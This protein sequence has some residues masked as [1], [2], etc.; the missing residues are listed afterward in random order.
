MRNALEIER[1]DEV[2][3]AT[4]GEEI[5]ISR[6]E[7][8]SYNGECCARAHRSCLLDY[9]PREE[10]P[11]PTKPPYIAFVGNLAFDIYEDGI[12]EF[13][14]PSTLKDIKIIKDRDEKP[15]GFGYVEF[16]SLD[17]LKDG[18]AKSGAVSFLQCAYDNFLLIAP[19][20]ANARSHR[21]HQCGRAS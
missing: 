2:E 3:Q 16:E 4:L 14:A 5:E 6:P 8:G 10:L 17:A 12:A 11:L 1:V 18:L 20:L 9:P 21:P 7:V 13:F 15:K 19:S